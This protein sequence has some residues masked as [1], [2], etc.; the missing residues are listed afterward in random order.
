MRR[1]TLFALATCA[2]AG[3]TVG[4]DYHRPDVA[5]AKAPWVGPIASGQVDDHWWR[6]LHDPKLD[7]LV[8]A[9]LAHNL[10]ITEAEANLRQARANREIAASAVA[11]QINASA[12]AQETQ[13]S[14]NGELPVNRL[15][16]FS[17]EF[18]LFDG[19]FDAS[20]ELDIWGVVRRSVQEARARGDQTAAALA[21]TRLRVVAEVVRAW[22]DLRAAQARLA[23]ARADVALRSGIV[24]LTALRLAAGEATQSDADTAAQRLAA[25]RAVLPG[26]QSQASAAAYTLALLTGRPPEATTDLLADE[27]SL[28]STPPILAGAIRS[29]VLE[30]RPDVRAAEADL[31]A[32]TA[33]IGV[34]T[35][36]LFPRFAIAGSVGQQS[37]SLSDLPLAGSTRFSAG[38]SFSWP[39]FSAGRIRAQIRAAKAG[40][41]AS[42]ARY[43]RAVLSALS[44]SETAINRYAASLDALGRYA[45]Q[46]Q[47]SRN[48]ASLVA[49]RF[50]K[51]ED[52]RLALL[53]AQSAER[54]AEQSEIAAQ[55]D[56]I[57]GYISLEKS[58]GGGWAEK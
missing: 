19:G 28:P 17:R 3:C 4:P 45:E 38:P 2:L 36:N 31:A 1:L 42:A 40:A 27:R 6:A 51:G 21:D 49:E 25:A 12:S 50:E 43:E 35:A 9:A 26:L 52:D 44:D 53:E 47:Q 15:P 34:Q 46:H 33:D 58:L 41:E 14:A 11:P 56:A 29:E 24:D 23:G 48:L 7:V 39:V 18:S 22:S 10:D 37:K 32:L 55:A 20:W 30:R 8:D 57:N 54:N 5:G 13:V 16:G